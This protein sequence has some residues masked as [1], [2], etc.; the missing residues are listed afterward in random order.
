MPQHFVTL[1]E[2]PRTLNGKVDRVALRIP[3][4]S[5]V[6][7]TERYVAPSTAREARR[8]ELWADVLTLERVGVED[9]CFE[10]GGHS[11][12]SLRAV[13]VIEEQVGH[14]LDPRLM[15]FHTVEQIGAIMNLEPAA[16]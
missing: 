13:A 10:L 5:A 8:V 16:S 7:A 9:D 12:L 4:A 3:E 14:R 2:I 11:L 1:D 15:F 6:A